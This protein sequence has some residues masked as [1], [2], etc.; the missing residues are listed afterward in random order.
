MKI[1]RLTGLGAFFK[2][3]RRIGPADIKS[4]RFQGMQNPAAGRI[5]RCQRLLQTRWITTAFGANHCGVGFSVRSKENHFNRL[6][7]L[8]VND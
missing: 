3:Q 4:G 1:S 6:Q 8:A 2:N 7:P 5:P